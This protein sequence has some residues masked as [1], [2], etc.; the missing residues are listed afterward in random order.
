MLNDNNDDGNI[1]LLKTEFY[2]PV[3][4]LSARDNQKLSNL[5]IESIDYVL[6]YTNEANNA[7]RFNAR[8]YYLPKGIIK[9]Y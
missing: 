2:V 8:K 3:V 7:R 5:F 9:N 6:V 1:L 4:T